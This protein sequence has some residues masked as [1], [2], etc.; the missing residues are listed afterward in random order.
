MGGRLAVDDAEDALAI[1]SDVSAVQAAAPH[2][3]RAGRC[4]SWSATAIGRPPFRACRRSFSRRATGP[5]RAGGTFS[6]RDE[7]D[8]AARWRCSARRSRVNLFGE[9]GSG[10]RRPCASGTCRSASSACSTPRARAMVGQDQDD[11]VLIPISTARKR[12]LADRRSD[13]HRRHHP[14]RGA[15]RGDM[16]RHRTDHRPPPPAP[17][18]R[19]ARRTISTVR[20]LSEVLTGA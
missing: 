19:P 1:S 11:I 15:L 12:V 7:V 5:W 16:A 8:A 13:P 3:M 6:E 17:C 4:R 10:R 14:V 9:A 20:N 2:F 18:P